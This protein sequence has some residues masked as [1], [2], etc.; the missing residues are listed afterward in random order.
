MSRL[1]MKVCAILLSVL[2][3]LLFATPVFAQEVPTIPPSGKWVQAFGTVNIRTCPSVG[4][5]VIQNNL[6][7]SA[8]AA[9]VPGGGYAK[10]LE[11][12]PVS[13]ADCVNGNCFWHRIDAGWVSAYYF[14][15]FS[16]PLPLAS[17]V[18]PNAAERCVMVDVGYQSVHLVQGGADIYRTWVA[19]GVDAKWAT[20]RGVHRVHLQRRMSWMVS[21]LEKPGE[22]NY[23]SLP[24]VPWVTYFTNSMIVFHGAYWHFSFRGQRSHGCVNMT[25]HDAQVVYDFAPVGTVVWVVDSAEHAHF[26]DPIHADRMN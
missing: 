16:D 22:A 15:D 11:T 17:P 4:C 19:T 23:F 1:S 25:N 20:T 6:G 18:C 9:Q 26:V 24:E 5:P 13:A 10:V 14:V 12:I 21:T 3:V 2:F 7:A 8:F